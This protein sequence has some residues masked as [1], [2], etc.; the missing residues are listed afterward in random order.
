M[1]LPKA[2][3]AP[4]GV[5]SFD[6]AKMVRYSDA[7]RFLW[8]DEQSG[9]VADVIYGRNQR[10]GA[11]TFKLKP[12]GFFRSSDTW[13]SYFDQHRYYFVVQGELT[14]HDPESGETAV[15][16]AGEVIHWR[17]A[18]WHFGYNFGSEETV[19]L[20][21]YAPQERPPHVAEIE[22][23]ATKPKI[24]ETKQGQFELLGQWP[25]AL[26]DSRVRAHQKGGVS[27]LT[28]SDAL[29]FVH[30]ERFPV[31]ESLF[32][33]SKELTAGTVNLIGGAKSEDR[34][35]PSDKVIFNLS[36]HL[37]IYLPETFE[38]FELNKWD[39]LYI[40][41]NVSHQYWNYSS[42]PLSFAFMVV[43]AYA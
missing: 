28:R 10:I 17:G 11:L 23:G 27:R 43:P 25:D 39:V 7:T 36:G 26:I 29:H 13:K 33:S 38:W 42:A 8:G 40:P 14:I 22:F 6:R 20:D 3:N 21:W 9:Q 19:V 30:G 1:G 35:H 41:A 34:T 2:I 24:R 31:L 4:R 15:A 12:G 32:V 37:H 16:S 18:K 5:V